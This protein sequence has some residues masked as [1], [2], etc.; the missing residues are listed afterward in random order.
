[1]S[2][3]EICVC[4][5]IKRFARTNVQVGGEEVVA[6][7]LE[8]LG[9]ALTHS[10]AEVKETVEKGGW[11]TRTSKDFLKAD[12]DDS[13]I[14]RGKNTQKR[15]CLGIF[16]KKMPVKLQEQIKSR[17]SR[18]LAIAMCNYIRTTLQ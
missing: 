3:V 13:V 8:D 17:K 1:M 6:I 18:S 15:R 16:M 14:T 5:Q 2:N 12:A 7:V 10:C 9:G 11:G 4:I